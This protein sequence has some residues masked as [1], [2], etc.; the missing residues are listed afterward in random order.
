[1][2]STLV[3]RPHIPH[4]QRNPRGHSA[5]D[6]FI[7]SGFSLHSS[8]METQGT[9][10]LPSKI[11]RCFPVLTRMTP[12]SDLNSVELLKFTVTCLLYLPDFWIFVDYS[13]QVWKGWGEKVREDLRCLFFSVFPLCF[14]FKFFFFLNEFSHE[15][16]R[17]KLQ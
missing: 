6:R 12:N 7:F 2:L 4:T 1:M 8:T 13:K 14:F 11:G 3:K 16:V 9:A 17:L 10:L 5:S 15:N